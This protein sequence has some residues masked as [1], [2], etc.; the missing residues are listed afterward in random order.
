LFDRGF[1][2]VAK[3]NGGIAKQMAVSVKV[4]AHCYLSGNILYFILQPFSE[5]SNAKTTPILHHWMTTFLV[6]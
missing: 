4:T 3:K 5:N 1:L 2:S 6:F